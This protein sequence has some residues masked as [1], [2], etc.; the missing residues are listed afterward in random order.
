[1]WAEG[2]GG[3]RGRGGSGEKHEDQLLSRKGERE[4]TR[5]TVTVQHLLHP[6]QLEQAVDVLSCSN[7]GHLHQPESCRDQGRRMKGSKWN[8]L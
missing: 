7:D 4:G 1:M 3:G 8:A 5:R 6:D 2:Y